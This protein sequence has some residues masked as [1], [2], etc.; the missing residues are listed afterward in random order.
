MRKRIDDPVLKLPPAEALHG[1]WVENGKDRA[2]RL[3]LERQ[4]QFALTAGYNR[5]RIAL[6]SSGGERQ[7]CADRQCSGRELAACKIRP[8][9]RGTRRNHRRQEL[10]SIDNG[11]AT[12]AQDQIDVV[13]AGHVCSLLQGFVNGVWLDAAELENRAL[14]QTGHDLIIDAVMLDAAAAIEQQHTRRRRH[15]IAQGLNLAGSEAYVGWVVYAEL[16]L[17]S[18]FSS[19]SLLHIPGRI[20]RHADP[21]SA[22]L[23]SRT[24]G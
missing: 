16:H 5:D 21:A 7:E 22:S 19:L 9:I 4:L 11:A 1:G 2:G 3:I 20:H 10:G 24:S 8:W 17:N 18:S 13:L 15:Q 6:R 12:H 23:V 14:R